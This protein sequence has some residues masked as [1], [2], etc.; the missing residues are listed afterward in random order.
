[1]ISAG[2]TSYHMISLPIKVINVQR[3]RNACF[4]KVVPRRRNIF[5]SLSLSLAFAIGRSP[6]LIPM[7]IGRNIGIFHREQVERYWNRS[8]LLSKPI[9]R[10]QCLYL[11]TTLFSSL[12][13]N[14]MYPSN[15]FN[16]E[17]LSL[18]EKSFE[19]YDVFLFYRYFFQSSIDINIRRR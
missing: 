8:I 9:K 6:R 4:Q 1:M 11:L 7:K 16:P 19:M 3:A 10:K 14:V 12:P 17:F 5:F 2:Y 15:L 18:D 13:C